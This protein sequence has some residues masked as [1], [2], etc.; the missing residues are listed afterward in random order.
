MPI[1]NIKR[2]LLFKAL[3]KEYTDD[4]FAEVCFEYGIELDEVTSEKDIIAREQGEDKAAN[5]SEDVIYKIEIP[6]NRHCQSTSA[7]RCCYFTKC[8]PNIGTDTYSSM[9]DLQEKLHQNICRRRALVAIGLHNLDTVQGPFY[10]DAK[11]PEDIKFKPLNKDKE[12]T[13]AELMELYKSDGH[14]KHYL[15]IIKDKPVY[16]IIYDSNGVVLSMPPIINGEHTKLSTNTRNIFIDAKIVLDTLVTMISEHCGQ[17]Y[18]A[19]VVDVI[20][21]DGK[22]V[23]YPELT[24]RHEIISLKDVYSLAGISLDTEK[25]AKLL[26]RMSLSTTVINEKEVK[27][28]VPPTR[29]DIHIAIA[30]GYNNIPRSM[31]KSSTIAQEFPINKLSNLLRQEIA[32]AGFTEALTFT[33]CSR[34][35]V[36]EKLNKNLASSKATHISNPK[37]QEFQVVRTTLLPGLLKTVASNRSM[38]LPLRLFEIADVVIKDD[39]TDTGARNERRLCAL[40]YNKSP[41]FEIIHGLADRSMQLLGIPFGKS[42]KGYYIKGADDPLY[43]PG[44][45]ADIIVH[46]NRIGSL[47]VL[48]PDVISKFDLNMP[49]SALECNITDFL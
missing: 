32:Q 42:D 21:P 23:T 40:Y 27:V 22:V 12:Y 30:Y 11:A 26:T 34:D 44:R 17:K 2:D 16:P 33:L 38:S 49:C 20:Q 24:T 13:A 1:I 15:H 41:G 18:S 3:Q 14:L 43:F 5:A 35:D 25:I 4:K 7:L 36:S 46:G 9:I 31:P 29:H 6:A 45:G 48:H 8:N 39:K 37:T 19:E 47:G 28:E 10:Y